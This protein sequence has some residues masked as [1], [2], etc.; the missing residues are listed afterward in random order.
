VFCRAFDAVRHD[1]VTT[2]VLALLF[3][4]LPLGTAQYLLSQVPWQYMVVTIGSTYLPGFFAAGVARWFCGLLFGVV[5]Q[6]A[7]T[8]PVV[9]EAQDRR[10]GIGESLGAATRVVLPLA[11]MGAVL[12]VS[13]IIGTTLLIV[14]GMLVFMLWATAPS[15]EADE[16]E[17]VFLA[18]S[19]SQ[20]LSEGAR[21]KAFAIVLI[22]VAITILTYAVLGFLNLMLTTTGSL[23]WST[24]AIVFRL[25]GATILNVLWGAVLASLYVELKQWKEGGSVETLE[26]VFA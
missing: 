23:A 17:G 3:A 7:F 4:A 15:A 25:A 11:V 20:E 16:R 19:R 9:A 1:L 26:Q 13:V 12:G 8:R 22:L 10:A 6:G 14:P 5:A 24:T 2:L 18:L 21:W